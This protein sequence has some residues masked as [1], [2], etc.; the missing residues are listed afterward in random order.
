MQHFSGSIIFTH[1]KREKTMWFKQIRLFQLNTQTLPEKTTLETQLAQA[2]IAPL[3]GLDKSSEGFVLPYDFSEQWAFGNE[4]NALI[5][6]KTTEKVLPSSMIHELLAEEVSQIEAKEHRPVGKK[7]KQNLKDNIIDTLLP[8][9][10]TRSSRTFALIDRKN[11]LL[12]V[13]AAHANKAENILSAM[14]EALGGLDAFLPQTKISPATLMTQ[15]LFDGFCADSHFELNNEVELKGQGEDAA[16]IKMSKQNLSAEEVKQ[17]LHTNKSVTQMGL[18][19]KERIAFVL[20]EDFALK[21]I[22]F[23]DVLQE[24]WSETGDDNES[25]A[26]SSQWIMSENLAQMINELVVHLGGWLPRQ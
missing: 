5:C 12:F 11:E 24:E 2:A 3:S 4:D 10:F 1:P 6:L 26:L 17:H 7:E 9:A 23:L 16:V 22:R 21:R 20:T 25:L 8:R 15:W 13:N 14:R 18:V 19:W